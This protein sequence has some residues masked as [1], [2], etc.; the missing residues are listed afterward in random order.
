M[1]EPPIFEADF[2]T[3]AASAFRG[4][5]KAI[6]YAVR[7]FEFSKEL[8][9]GL[10]R[11]NIDCEY[12]ASPS[13]QL[14]LSLWSDGFLYYRTCQ[15][16]KGGWRHNIAFTGRGNAIDPEVIVSLFEQGIS[17]ADQAELLELWAGVSPEV[18]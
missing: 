11:L 12:W 14:R 2:L 3:A 5:S 13:Y 1:N 16:S 15:R 17:L 18:E 9:D 4:R 10:E 8:D 7:S 6:K